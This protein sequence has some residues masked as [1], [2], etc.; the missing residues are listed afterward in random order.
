[1]N[2]YVLIGIVVAF[3]TW[4]GGVW[5]YGRSTMEDAVR[6]EYAEK[7]QERQELVNDIRTALRDEANV[8][9]MNLEGQIGGMRANNR[10]IVNN[11]H[12]EKE[13]HHVLTSVDCA[14]PAS[15]VR[16]RNDARRRATD[17]GG[18]TPGQPPRPVPAPAPAAGGAPAPDGRG[19]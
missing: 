7:S 1:M 19:R 17:G 13:V 12:R 11:I 15:T 6:A 16:L 10:T 2:P 18:P 4:T 9:S 8:I 14:A 5:F 3:A